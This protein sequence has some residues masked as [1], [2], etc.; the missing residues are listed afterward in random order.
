MLSQILNFF[1]AANQVTVSKKTNGCWNI[2]LL[3]TVSI[4]SAVMHVTGSPA[5][6]DLGNGGYALPISDWILN[7]TIASDDYNRKIDFG[8]VNLSIDNAEFMGHGGLS[9]NADLSGG[10]WVRPD[11]RNEITAP[12]MDINVYGNTKW[13]FEFGPIPGIPI[14]I[15]VR[16]TPFL[17]AAL[18]INFG[19]G[20]PIAVNDVSGNIGGGADIA[21]GV[22]IPGLSAGGYFR[23]TIRLYFAAVPSF[24]FQKVTLEAEVGVYVEALWWEWEWELWHNSWSSNPGTRVSTRSETEW[25]LNDRSY[26]VPGYS[27]FA[28][29]DGNREGALVENVYSN[30]QPSL[31]VLE[32][33][34]MVAAWTY[35][36]PTKDFLQALEIAYSV[37]DP[38]RAMWSAP[39][40]ITSDYL[41]D[42]NPKLACVGDG[43][44]LA[45]WQ[46][47]PQQLENT[48]SPFACVENVELAYSIFDLNTGAWSTPQLITSNNTYEAPPTLASYDGKTWLVYLRDSDN[49]IFTLDNQKIIATELTGEGWGTEETIASGITVIGSPSLSLAGA[50][51]GVLTFVRDMDD[52]LFTIADREV[53]YLRYD[54]SWGTPT[55]LTTDNIEERSPSAGWANNQWYLSW[56]ETQPIENQKYTT[57]VRF[58]ELINGQLAGSSTL[59]ENQGVAEQFLLGEIQDKLYLLYQVGAKGTP[60]LI[61]YDGTAW[62]NVENFQWSPNDENALTSQLA[63]SIG[64][65]HLGAVGVTTIQMEGGQTSTSL[66][67]STFSLYPEAQE[68]AETPWVLIG[69]IIAALVAIGIIVSVIFFRRKRTISAGK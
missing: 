39:S 10:F 17:N 6:F 51:D 18:D 32:N 30:P 69:G 12:T 13:N 65:N 68:V 35:D 9:L 67:A 2:H 49:N 31:A 21:A 1:N 7:F 61:R 3:G 56:I 66:H 24:E 62:E 40:T 43:K 46:R 22:G 20:G 54:G 29:V 19:V 34:T 15:T 63:V 8:S 58:G 25:K 60:K 42:C 36:D 47:V 26:L 23:G 44:V 16:V 59:L 38:E 48:V 41:F 52:N 33:G 27:T 5:P 53:F 14:P 4:V 28:W 57:S 37:Y 64:G 50:N 55:R 45:V 11:G